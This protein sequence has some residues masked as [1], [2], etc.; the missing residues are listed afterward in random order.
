M[1]TI[2][3]FQFL[4]LL[5]LFMFGPSLFVQAKDYVTVFSHEKNE[6][7]FNTFQLISGNA[8]VTGELMQ[9]HKLSLT[10]DAAS[11][12]S[13]SD[14]T[15]QDY[16]LN[17]TF[18]SPTG[19]VYVVPGFFAA[20]GN[21][22]ESS[23][24][25]GSKWRC[26]FTPL[27]TGIWTYSTSFRTGAMIAVSF[28]AS[29]GSPV[30]P[31]DSDTG[32]FNI[33]ETNKSGIDFRSKG[34]LEYVGEHFQRWT[35]GEYF[36]K[37]G[38]D[39]PEV[40]LEYND[41]DDYDGVNYPR[42][43]L[44]HVNDWNTGD[45][46]WQGDK[47]KG[48]I[49]VINY[50]SGKGINSQYFVL[51]RNRERGSPFSDPPNSYFSYDI[52]RMDQW[53]VVFDH[54][55]T[56]GLNVHLVFSESTNQSFFETEVPSGDSMFSDARKIY[57][58]EI[59]A[60]FGYLNAVTWNIGEENGWDRQSLVWPG[61]AARGLTTQQQLDFTAYLDGLA[62]YNDHITVHNGHA[63]DPGIYDDL[64]GDNSMTGTSM[65][66]LLRDTERSK[67]STEHLREKSE[68]SGKK[69]V[70]YY[71]EAWY[72][73]D[74]GLTNFRKSVV[75]SAL[76]A[77][78]AGIE[79]YATNGLDVTQEDLRFYD[80]YYTQMRHAYD[81]YHDNNLPFYQ[82][83]NQDELVEN[84]WAHGV[85]GD[86]YV[87][88]V[89]ENN[90]G[91]TTMRLLGDYEVKW[92]DPRTG[93]AL[94]DGSITNVSA[95]DAVNIGLPPSE[96]NLDWVA[97]VRTDP[98]NGPINVTG[99]TVEPEFIELGVGSSYDI[100]PQVTPANADN[101]NLV[102]SSSNTSIVAVDNQGNILA[103]GPGNATVTVTTVDAGFTAETMV[104]V[105]ESTNFCEALGTILL[106]RY[107]N[108]I[109]YHLD[110]LYASP[111][112]PDNPSLT[113]ELTEFKI[114]T[115]AADQYG[116]R[117]SGYLC[118]PE[119]GLYTFWIAGDDR[120][121]LKLSSDNEPANTTRIAYND[122]FTGEREWN[123]V[124]T[125]RSIEIQL[126][127][128]EKYYIEAVMKEGTGG[129]HMTVGWRKP[130]DR[131]GEVP[132]EVIPGSVLSPNINIAVTGIA[133]NP[134]QIEIEIGETTQLTKEV[135][136]IFASNNDVIWT[137]D[138]SSLVTVDDFGNIEGIGIG[139]A[140]ITVTTVDGNFSAET[141]VNVTA[142]I[143]V[144][145]GITLA[146]QNEAIVIGETLQLTETISPVD[147]SNQSVIWTS[148]D[149]SIVTVATD[150]TI[151]GISEGTAT[152]TV[153]TVDGGF[154]AETVVNVTAPIVS[155]TGI[156]L[157]TQNEAI[158]IRE[159]LDLTETIMPS[160]ASNQSVVWT[161]SDAS[162][163]TVDTN[164]T[165][166]GESEGV[167]TITVTTVDGNYAATTVVTVAAAVIN[168]TGIT[169]AATQE[170]IEVG[171][172][173]QLSATIQPNDA[174][175]QN[176]VWA[177]TDNA[178]VTV[179]NQ[180]NITGITE[181]SA[182]IQATSED[183][184]FIAE[185]MVNVSPAIVAVTGI[186]IDK[187][188]VV[189]DLNE[190]AIL[191]ATIQP[192]N[193][194]NQEVTW[195]SSDPNVVTVDANG[196]ITALMI[197][198]ATILATALD[199]GFTAETTVEV[200]ENIIN[201]TGISVETSS[202]TID[203]GSQLQLNA[204][205]EPANA[206]NQSVSWTS[207]DPNI[208]SVN[209][210]GEITGL[211]AGITQINAISDDG[212]Y[213]ATVTVN[214][215]AV[216]VGV[217]GIV[218]NQSSIVLEVGEANQLDA[219]IEPSNASNTDV[220]WVSFDET[221]ASVDNQGN[222]LGI[223]AGTTIISVVTVDGSFSAEISVEVKEENSS[224][225]QV[226]QIVFDVESL[227][228]EIGESILLN[229]IFLP[230]NAEK[231]TVVWS[232]NDHTIV[233]INQDGT[234]T[235]LAAG[236]SIIKGITEDG[237]TVELTINVL[238]EEVLMVYPNPADDFIIITGVS[239]LIFLSIFSSN[240]QLLSR[241]KT[242]AGGTR[243]NIKFFPAGV[244]FIGLDNGRKL[245]FIKQ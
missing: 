91:S 132:K 174:S 124:A 227:N 97:L 161:S 1:R 63:N 217:T 68:G 243:I 26:N 148:S 57:F 215:E 245:P 84:G 122:I 145:S 20:D 42:E 230:A 199:G 76:T 187:M 77:G 6:V 48:L 241:V 102:W 111:N 33:A 98:N 19:K 209:A 141:V 127:Q 94:Q 140:R 69:W 117:V 159:I 15:F 155:V 70:I 30:N 99:V 222:I 211:K 11:V 28:D 225:A 139:T 177:T 165:I 216:I 233:A 53:E 224:E 27:E 85:D 87:V 106:E 171:E 182:I 112:Y 56:K 196:T 205:I 218:L 114:P 10:W 29:L 193:A 9:Y 184:N 220:V 36:M 16:R 214:V 17:V 239:D 240:G 185:T 81:F 74:M 7:N 5:A 146:T 64:Q 166:S 50:L 144:V 61:E 195:S 62:Y 113:Q 41:I 2:N 228:L 51:H 164:G 176:I 54:M 82:M 126:R 173:L 110:D 188:N 175:N 101:K 168:V 151:T 143:I 179:D 92:F 58:R 210:E 128:G 71:D 200:S 32:T 47:G 242:T 232:T 40:L 107:D 231:P 116:A 153:T 194:T 44:N 72:H 223:A 37:I 186:T 235:G 237:L 178:T 93:G 206:T 202:L 229:P 158:V 39:S 18:T 138:D 169:L 130:S 24:V 73:S 3:S 152:I 31:I 154:S 149:A 55:V 207:D 95:G 52:S 221:I 236:T 120:A 219:T 180:G 119:T 212:S 181:G 103:V 89:E 75:W 13:E 90:A 104:S 203:E 125:Q 66:G 226:S 65:Q 115:R 12:F 208:V 78:A 23:A 213:I 35:N 22:R 244:Y 46:T 135:A 201:V 142:P 96:T 204:T 136:P 100:R 191:I 38:S 14:N 150:G 121:E 189:L 163:I 167:A 137:S 162:I 190:T 133:V 79:H 238:K 45:P 4:H 234:V 60:R 25:S 147:A 108:V 192:N 156:T 80:E 198:N 118:A 86:D 134:T 183:G 21:A 105:I 88:Y 49:G 83:Y 131:Y 197:G 67:N 123:K 109:G 172:S 160:N 34:K 59:V 129:D 43:Y 8:I 170:N 157:A